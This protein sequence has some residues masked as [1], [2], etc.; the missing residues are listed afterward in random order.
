VTVTTP[1]PAPGGTD[2]G[3][4][5]PAVTPAAPG[6]GRVAGILGGH[7]L[8]YALVWTAIGAVL[9]TGNLVANGVW[10]EVDGSAWD[11]QS[12]VFQYAFLA[13]GIVVVTGYLP[14]MISQ[15]VTRRA[16][17]DGGLVA[18]GA[19]AAA[20]AALTTLA[21]GIEDL[22]FAANDWPHVLA[23]TEDLHIYDR[24][25][26]YGLILV[27]VTAQ[28]LVHAVAGLVIGGGI[29]RFGWVWG[30]AFVV[31]GAALAVVGEYLMGSG[32][33]GVR[34]GDAVGLDAPPVGVGIAGSVGVVAA[35]ALMARWLAR[36]MPI[37]TRHASWWR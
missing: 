7:L 2:A 8:F 9:L 3:T 21:F 28:Y 30:A 1:T 13:G 35:G 25:D 23:G 37:E 27:E 18:L 33:V 20:G 32:F 5:V 16:A 10:G 4:P 26:Q 24:P 15:G 6:A 11:G 17:L 36:G 12:I 29:F 22:V 19:L 14:T 34:L 31:A